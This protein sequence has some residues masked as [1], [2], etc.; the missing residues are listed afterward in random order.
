MNNTSPNWVPVNNVCGILDIDLSYAVFFSA[1]P[2]CSES[3]VF[4]FIDS[5]GGPCQVVVGVAEFMLSFFKPKWVAHNS[6]KSIE[7][8]YNFTT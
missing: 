7:F 5:E 6:S 8:C 3:N 2:K 1:A 4:F